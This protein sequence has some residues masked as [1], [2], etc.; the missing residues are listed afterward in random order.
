MSKKHGGEIE[1]VRAA[2]EKAMKKKAEEDAK[3]FQTISMIA[4]ASG[5]KIVSFDIDTGV[6][7]IRCTNGKKVECA[8]SIGDFLDSYYATHNEDGP[9]KEEVNEPVKE[10]VRKPVIK[11]MGKGI[12]WV[13]S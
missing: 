10:E 3:I 7:D 5:C 1:K 9:V 6:I 13:M 11:N 8:V 2:Q 4:E 12:G